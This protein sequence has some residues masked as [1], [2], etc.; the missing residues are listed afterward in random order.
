MFW[1]LREAWIGSAQLARSFILLVLY[2]HCGLTHLVLWS[3]RRQPD[4]WFWELPLTCLCTIRV[5]SLILPVSTTAKEDFWM[6][7]NLI[8]EVMSECGDLHSVVHFGAWKITTHAIFHRINQIPLR[9]QCNLHIQ[10]APQKY[11]LSW[12]YNLRMNGETALF[13]VRFVLFGHSGNNLAFVDNTEKRGLGMRYL[14]SP[15][16]QGVRV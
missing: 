16:R 15:G 4:V 13:S 2:R 6:W 8:V 3:Y 7:K 9:G 1:A 5:W 14:P 10:V 12:K 11:A